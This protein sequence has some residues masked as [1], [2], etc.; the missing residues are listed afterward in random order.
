MAKSWPYHV[1]IEDFYKEPDYT[2]AEDYTWQN[3][4]EEAHGLVEKLLEVLGEMEWEDKTGFYEL[5]RKKGIVRP[6]DRV[7]ALKWLKEDLESEFE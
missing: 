1:G 4:A 6:A 7:E 2:G 3:L 5:I